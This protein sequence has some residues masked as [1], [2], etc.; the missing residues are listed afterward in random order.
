MKTSPLRNYKEMET[1]N[2]NHRSYNS[3]SM[4][5]SFH[6]STDRCT[7]K[8]IICRIY[9]ICPMMLLPSMVILAPSFTIIPESSVH[10]SNCFP[11]SDWR[12]VFAES[13]RIERLLQNGDMIILTFASA[14]IHTCAYVEPK[15]FFLT[16]HTH[17]KHVTAVFKLK[18]P[19]AHSGTLQLANRKFNGEKLCGGL[20]HQNC[21][22]WSG[23]MIFSG[24]GLFLTY[25]FCVPLLCN[26]LEQLGFAATR[27]SYSLTWWVPFTAHSRHH[28]TM[29]MSRMDCRVLT[30]LICT[31]A[32]CSLLGGFPRARA[33]EATSPPQVSAP[34][35]RIEAS[36][37][38]RYTTLPILLTIKKHAACHG[39]DS[40]CCGSVG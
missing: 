32:W 15:T 14:C 1:E 37:P 22:C 13:S 28:C 33:E 8:I 3:I 2:K 7:H 34:L 18:L 26:Y 30:V 17:N 19:R 12:K 29:Q 20:G 11:E 31:D 24:A 38:Y 16:T 27:G 6:R 5:P 21:E 23:S 40:H 25:G 4:H 10:C 39:S 9:H 35:W 36:L